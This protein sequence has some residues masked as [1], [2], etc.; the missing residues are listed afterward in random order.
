LTDRAR[1]SAALALVRDTGTR[2]VQ[3]QFVDIF[4]VLK[5]VNI[6][7][8]RFE[9]VLEHGE[10]FDGSSVDGFAR[11][12]ENDM[13][14]APDVTTLRTL[15]SS[16]GAGV[17]AVWVMCHLLTPDGEPSVGD[18]RAVLERT[19]RQAAAAGFDYQV[20]PEVEFLLYREG[21][22]GI[23]IAA[24]DAG[25]FDQARDSSAVVRE[26]MVEALAQLGV[27]VDGSHHEVSPG[28]HEIDIAFQPAIQAADA[29]VLLHHVAREVSER[30]GLHVSFMPKPLEG[31]NGNGMHTHQGLLDQTSK[32][33][34]FDDPDDPYRMSSTARSF[35]AGQLDHAAALAAITAPLV[36]SYKRLISGYEAPTHVS[37][38]RNSRSALIRIPRM[39]RGDAGGT[40]VELRCPDSSC[41]PYVALSGMLAAGLDG[42][43]RGLTPV[44]PD[45]EE[46]LQFDPGFAAAHYVRALPS[47]LREALDAL[48]A[49]EVMGDALGQQLVERFVEAKLIECEQYRTHVSSWE[50]HRYLGLH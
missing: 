20:A 12:L 25:Y 32:A 42:I 9:S 3:L 14:L 23:P 26:E 29:I 40:R 49:D 4:G 46:A 34:L 27:A 8:A 47:S 21:E 5:S 6:P 16:D 7:A 36:N 31:S 33:N 50:V 35:V 13:Y 45:E 44:L 18:T 48:V 24:D 11:V 30:H 1:S 2:Y 41:N 15:P 10:W 39:S 17:P 43:D 28:Q 19:V 38:A 22:G 37:W